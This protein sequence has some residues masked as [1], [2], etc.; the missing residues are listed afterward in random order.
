MY[1]I[2]DRGQDAA[3][4]GVAQELRRFV[5]GEERLHEVLSNVA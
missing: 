4:S 5:G 3:H 1:T 2:A